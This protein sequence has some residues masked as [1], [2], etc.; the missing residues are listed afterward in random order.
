MSDEQ[1]RIL[2][3]R[4][5]LRR[6]GLAG[7]AA[8]A[9]PGTLVSTAEAAA[10]APAAQAPAAAAAPR[11]EAVENL[12]A[13]E[14]DLLDAIL[15]RLIPSDQQGPG[16]R[17][18]RVIH[19]IDRALGGALASS[20][21][22]YTAGL[23][24]LDRYARSSRGKGFLELSNTDRDSV[25]IDVETGAATGF[26]GSSAQF[27]TLVLNHTRQGMFGDPYYGGNA[28]FAGWDLIG[29]PGIRTMVT[30]ADQKAYEAGQLKANH[31]SAYDYDTFNKATAHN[32]EHAHEDRAHGD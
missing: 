24:S 2:S 14:A 27:F 10:P 32:T 7:A 21:N 28:N 18:A 23:A 11:R 16:A 1:P 26:A 13:T 5:I 6:A 20:K 12:T 31:K 9:V 4:D 8:V 25:L 19:Y 29:Y 17:E 3:R 15:D 22:A 30:A